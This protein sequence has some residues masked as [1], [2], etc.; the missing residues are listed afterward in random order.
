MAAVCRVL[1]ASRL[2]SPCQPRDSFSP[3]LPPL[4]GPQLPFWAL[5]TQM[6]DLIG[7]SLCRPGLP[8]AALGAPTPRPGLCVDADRPPDQAGTVCRT[9]GPQ[10]DGGLTHS[11][12]PPT[13]VPSSSR[14]CGPSLNRL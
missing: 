1:R 9:P 13:S 3:L 8:P 14:L 7:S 12:P 11:R 6:W 10:H 4:L 2:P 5:E